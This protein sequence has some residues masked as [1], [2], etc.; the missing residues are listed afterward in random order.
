MASKTNRPEAAPEDQS[1][2]LQTIEVLRELH[3]VKGPIF[4]GV[5]AANGWR[6]GR[7]MTEA[8]FLQAVDSFASAPMGGYRGREVQKQC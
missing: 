2:P 4:A 5:C 7:V 3:R 1:P 8:A 6:P